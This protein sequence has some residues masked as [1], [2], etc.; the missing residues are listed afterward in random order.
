[1][2]QSDVLIIGSGISALTC[3]V[4]LAKRGKRVT[5]LEQYDKPGGYMHCFKR[6]G[7][8]FDT[9]A[10]YVGAMDPG[11]P[12]H[13]L[14]TYLNVLEEDMFVPL[15]PEGFDTFYFP[16]F[17]V[18]M[19]KGYP[20]AVER[21][22]QVFPQESRAIQSYFSAIQAAVRF[23]PTYEFDDAFNEVP[24]KQIFETTLA[25]VVQ[26]L[27]ANRQLQSLLFAYC[28]LHGVQA[29]EVAFGFHALVVDSLIRSPYGFK[30]GG[31]V[32]ATRFQSELEKYGGQI[33]LKKKVQQ[34]V[35][36]DRHIRE[37]ICSDGTSY[38]AEW[39]VSAIHPKSTFA[40]FDDQALM[41]VAFKQRLE[42]LSESVGLLGVSALTE[43]P[44]DPLRNYY[45]FDSSDPKELLRTTGNVE[46]PSAVFLSSARRYALEGRPLPINIH[47]AAPVQWFSDWR[48][49]QYGRRP[50]EYK[51]FKEQL[52][53][54][55]F[56][57][58]ERYRPGFRSR[59]KNFAVS[60]PLSN[61][62]FNGSPDGSAY[63][64]YH[65]VQNTGP[66]AI[67]PRTRALNLLLTGQNNLFPGL[68][69]AAISGLRTSGH[70]IGIKP[71]LHELKELRGQL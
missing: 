71:I 41:P 49:T 46:L 58:I 69:G 62:H 54:N 70:V 38:S 20:Q 40:L 17:Q 5:L 29:H 47:A 7:E 32:L 15:N 56:S 22:T 12:F 1:M 65:S 51:K 45:F 14:L 30:G 36:K 66:R 59:I 25:E 26:G 57:S 28:T 44:L 9:G 37:V 18:E 27:T 4:L 8:R 24:A 39:I 6:F 61:L 55:V 63:G 43:E 21:L 53:E 35:V 31:D 19:P 48:D 10:H 2:N 60:T 52:A 50:A 16:E 23:F 3:G 64:L 33:L 13:T 68:L 67:G 42:A 34:L 11:H